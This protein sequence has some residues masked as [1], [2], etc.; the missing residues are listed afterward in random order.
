MEPYG[1]DS[2]GR[3]EPGAGAESPV[4]DLAEVAAWKARKRYPSTLLAG[5][6][7][8]GVARERGEGGWVVEAYFA[9]LAA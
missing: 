2:A 4:A 8:F 1:E 6:P 9:G 7:V 5:G 3:S